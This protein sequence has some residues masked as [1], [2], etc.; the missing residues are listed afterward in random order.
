MDPFRV[1]AK[2]APNTQLPA[3]F[4]PEELAP[5]RRAFSEFSVERLRHYLHHPPA[6][7]SDDE[8]PAPVQDLDGQLEHEVEAILNVKFSMRAGHPY[9]LVRWIGLDA[10]GDTWEPLETLTQ[11]LTVRM[12]FV[13]LSRLTGWSYLAL[14]PAFAFACFQWSCALFAR[15]WVFRRPE[16]W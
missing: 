11:R 3:S 12:L 14:R 4:F 2:T 8:K 5:S 6:L 9:I 7:S 10:A 13:L 16:P 1:L 15:C